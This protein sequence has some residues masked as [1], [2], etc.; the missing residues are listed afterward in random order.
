MYEMEKLNYNIND[1]EPYLD[2]NTIK[3]HRILEKRYF[4][5]LNKLLI[6]NNYNYKYLYQYLK[7]LLDFQKTFYLNADL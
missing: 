4:D 6:K 7:L 2:P 5:N 3:Y 1:L